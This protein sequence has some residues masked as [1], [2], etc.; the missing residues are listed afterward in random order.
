MPT[1]TETLKACV[2]TIVSLTFSRRSCAVLVQ[3]FTQYLVELWIKNWGNVYIYYVIQQYGHYNTGRCI[4]RCTNNFSYCKSFILERGFM[5]QLSRESFP[6]TIK[7][8]VSRLFD[9][10][11]RCPLLPCTCVGLALSTD[12]HSQSC[13]NQ[14]RV[15]TLTQLL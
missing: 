4:I 10:Q 9:L 2:Y 8:H 12:H 15:K 14:L 5:Q 3:I 1:P 6:I 11:L 7:N 13:C